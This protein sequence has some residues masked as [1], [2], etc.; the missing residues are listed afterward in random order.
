M[1]KKLKQF[2]SVSRVWRVVSRMPSSNTRR[3]AHGCPAEKKYHR[4]A[5]APCSANTTHGSTM[6][7]FDLDIFWPSASTMWPRQMTSR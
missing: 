7:P 1:A 3:G 5:S 2:H 6:L 4:S